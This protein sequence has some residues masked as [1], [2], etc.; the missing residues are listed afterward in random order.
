MLYSI[1]PQVRTELRR[2]RKSISFSFVRCFFAS[3]MDMQEGVG[4]STLGAF[5]RD[6]SVYCVVHNMHYCDGKFSTSIVIQRSVSKTPKFATS[7]QCS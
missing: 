4:G 6:A 5:Y 2:G 3:L 7:G 1:L